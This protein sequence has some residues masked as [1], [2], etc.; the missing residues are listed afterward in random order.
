MLLPRSIGAENVEA[1]IKENVAELKDPEVVGINCVTEVRMPIVIVAVTGVI[2]DIP[3]L[4]K[5]VTA[6]SLRK[7][8]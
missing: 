2:K 6:G 4:N 1:G 8:A 3:D 7:R 5:A